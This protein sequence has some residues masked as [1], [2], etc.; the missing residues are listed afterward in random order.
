MQPISDASSGGGGGGGG[1]GNRGGQRCAAACPV[2]LAKLPRVAEEA[3]G[4]DEDK[5]EGGGAPNDTAEG[6]VNIVNPKP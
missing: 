4:K 3:G 5:G 2:F 6:L 1:G